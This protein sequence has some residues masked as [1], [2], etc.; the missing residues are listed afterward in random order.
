MSL[1]VETRILDR[2]A[3]MCSQQDCDLFVLRSELAFGALGQIQVAEHR[4]ACGHGH[5][6]ERVHRWVIRWK[7]DRARIVA[8]IGQP[9]GRGVVDQHPEDS[10]SS[11]KRADQPSLIVVDA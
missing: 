5:P 9:Q 2:H 10:P 4:A 8:K 6:E 1:G 3:G 11:R 7:A